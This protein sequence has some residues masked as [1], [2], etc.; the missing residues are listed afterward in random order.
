MSNLRFM[1]DGR[2]IADTDTPKLLEMEDDD[3]IEVFSRQ[4]G[5]Q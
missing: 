2:R 3:V 4:D 5:G 1:H